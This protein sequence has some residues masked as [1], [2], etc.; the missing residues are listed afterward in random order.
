VAEVLWWCRA[1]DSW[2]QAIPVSCN[3]FGQV[4]HTHVPLSPSA[5]IFSGQRVVMLCSWE[6]NTVL[7]EST[8][9]YEQ[10]YDL[11]ADCLETGIS[12]GLNE[13]SHWIW[14][15]LY[16]FKVV[17]NVANSRAWHRLVFFRPICEALVAVW[18]QENGEAK[19]TDKTENHRAELQRVVRI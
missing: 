12:T 17:I 8:A 7:V 11:R 5:I 14:E 16:L 13:C 6:D 15:Y 18:W 3:D 2:L 4:V 1:L 9:A 10:V 19:D